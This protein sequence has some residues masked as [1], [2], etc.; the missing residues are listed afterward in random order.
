M[1]PKRAPGRFLRAVPVL[2][3][4]VGLASSGCVRKDRYDALV[5]DSA[6]AKLDADGRQKAADA[7]IQALQAQIAAAESA[8]Q[9]RE[10]RV[11]DLTTQNHNVQ[12]SLDEQTAM[13]EQLRGELGRLGKDVDK[14]L[15]DR[16]VLSKALDDAK[17]RLEELRK[18][19]AASE[20][21]VALFKDFERRFKPLIDAGQI[22]VGMRR[23]LLEIVIPGDVLF[24]AGGREVR[25]AG[26][27]VLMEVARSLQ[28]AGSAPAP[29]AAAATATAQPGGAA[30]PVTAPQ[31]APVRRY[32]VTASVDPTGESAAETASPAQTKSKPH[33]S[34]PAHA[35][36]P[37]PEG[38]RPHGHAPSAWELSADQAVAVVEYLVSLGVSPSNLVAAGAGS[39]D[40]I[41]P[42]D[43]AAARMKN[44]RV[45]IA[46]LPDGQLP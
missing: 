36:E 2:I 26:K 43:D 12:A 41:A 39:S 31:A 34:S 24:D 18:A 13:N 28:I 7:N 35:P 45:E 15:A 21:R 4:L 5:A 25:G 10:A 1:K 22:G 38:K 33:G 19:Q 11:S 40:P 17:Q 37:R 16:G 29:A 9:D 6:K 30:A 3:G 20:A 23:G 42:G 14:I 46:L 8:A 27:G 32:L 44:R